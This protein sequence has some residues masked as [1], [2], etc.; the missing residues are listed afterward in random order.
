MN[1]SR[2]EFLKSMAAVGLGAAA[3][4]AGGADKRELPEASASKLPPWRGFNLLNKFNGQNKPFAERDFEWLAELGFDFVRLPMDYRMWIE[5]ADWTR[6][7]ESTLKQIDQAVDLGTRYGIH[8]CLNFHRA[9]GYT[10]ANPPEEKS[11]WSDDEALRV[12]GLHWAHF[13][14]RYKGIPNRQLS[15]DLFNEPPRLE[16]STYRRVVSSVC[17]A[18]RQR[19]AGRLIICDGRDWG[20]T[21]PVELIGLGVAASTRGYS[22]IHVSHYRASWMNGANQWPEPTWPIEQDGV[23][24]DKEALQS[25]QIAPW[26]GLETRG[27]GVMVGEFGAYN[28]TPHSVVL[29]WMRDYVD[30]WT[31]AGWGWAMWN[32]TGSMGIIDSDRPDVEYENWHGHKLDREMLRLVQGSKRE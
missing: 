25:R 8:V 32:F 12:C 4:V 22:P 5:E 16:P 28:K 1:T 30:L 14:E 18:I 13:A 3:S 2:R 7:R 17:N 15:F 31:A 27:I 23:H 19:D 21:A 11:L 6:F 9:P 10:V 29:A 26:K 20:N 24:W